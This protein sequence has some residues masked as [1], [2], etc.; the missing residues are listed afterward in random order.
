MQAREGQFRRRRDARPRGFPLAFDLLIAEVAAPDGFQ[1]RMLN[2]RHRRLRASVTSHPPGPSQMISRRGDLHE[3]AAHPRKWIGRT[4]G[5]RTG[6][7]SAAA[8]ALTLLAATLPTTAAAKPLRLGATTILR[9]SDGTP[10]RVRAYRVVDPLLPSDDAFTPQAGRRELGVYVSVKNINRF[11]IRFSPTPGAAVIT[12]GG[13]KLSPQYVTLN[14]GCPSWDETAIISGQT[15]RGCIVFRVP[16]AA[17]LRWFELDL[18][19]RPG[20]WAL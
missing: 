5:E 12:R 13:V 16:A 4:P 14:D 17:R 8:L 20:Q 6:K 11:G 15:R 3:R 7:S 10:V 2:M 9:D 1:E 19:G 18:G